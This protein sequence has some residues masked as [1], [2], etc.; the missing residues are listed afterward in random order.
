[1]YNTIYTFTFCIRIYISTLYILCPDEE[2]HIYQS[3]QEE[4]FVVD[5]SYFMV[6]AS[7]FIEM[8]MPTN[9][10]YCDKTWLVL[11]H[12][13]IDHTL[14]QQTR[15]KSHIHNYSLLQIVFKNGHA[16]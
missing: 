12:R 7:D 15:K 16:L 5:E 13:T 11:K 6:N 1:M 3:E 8:I 14:C 10:N 2:L 9:V 4:L